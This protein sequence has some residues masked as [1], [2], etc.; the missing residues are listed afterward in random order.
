LTVAASQ[1]SASADIL[2]L[3]IYA[4]GKWK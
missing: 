3:Q 4:V 2:N 1:S